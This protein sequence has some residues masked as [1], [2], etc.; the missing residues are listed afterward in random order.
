MSR[1]I[2]GIIGGSGLGDILG[3]HIENPRSI[4]VDTPFGK[5]SGPVLVGTLGANEVAF[6]NRHGTGHV[7]SPSSVPYAANIYALKKLGAVSVIATAAVG[8]LREEIVPGDLVIVDQVIDKTW[9]RQNSF[10][11]DSSMVVHSELAYPF[12]PRLSSILIDHAGS[13]NVRTHSK[14]T[15][16][17]MEGPQFSTRAESLMHRT[18][19]GDLIGMTASPEFKLAREAQLCYCLIAFASDYDCWR[20]RKNDSDKHELLKEIYSNLTGAT[21]NA[22]KLLKAALS[23]PVSL[24]EDTCHCRKS[25]ELALWT[26]KDCVAQSDW[27][28]LGILFE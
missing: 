17:C 8:S 4:E 19:G 5:P 7:F 1:N 27:D 24:C 18:W 26:R 22:V 9:R 15:Y 25:L 6:I 12:C 28:K 11:N 13:I 14:A 20:Q 2:T 10:F 23:S 16:V 3:E 21:E